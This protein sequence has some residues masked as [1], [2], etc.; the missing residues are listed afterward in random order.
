M[1]LLCFIFWL[2]GWR[3]RRAERLSRQIFAP[4]PLRSSETT[5]TGGSRWLLSTS[6][7][8]MVTSPPRPPVRLRPNPP[9]NDS[10][11]PHRR[12]Q[13]P[14]AA[15]QGREEARR[16]LSPSS[17]R[18]LLRRSRSPSSAFKIAQRRRS[19]PMTHLAQEAEFTQTV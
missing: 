18:R 4:E 17:S 6:V 8:L 2:F 5:E 14:R 10:A 15:A 12:P 7:S 11:S 9:W 3:E 13:R 19:S 1:E 16:R